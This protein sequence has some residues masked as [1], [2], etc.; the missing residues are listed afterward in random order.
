MGRTEIMRE[1][2]INK[3]DALYV[4]KKL[5]KNKRISF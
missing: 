4:S 3:S 2:E 1:Q 5:S